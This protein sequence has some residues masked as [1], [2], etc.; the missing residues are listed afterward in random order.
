[1]T[2]NYIA[3]LSFVVNGAIELYSKARRVATLHDSTRSSGK[4]TR[5]FIKESLCFMALQHAV[6]AKNKN[7][8]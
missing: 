3:F 7:K 4:A 5:G 1:M 2:L 6:M 8:K